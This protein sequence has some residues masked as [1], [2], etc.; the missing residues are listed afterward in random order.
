METLGIKKAIVIAPH[1]DDEILGCG[2]TISKLVSEGSK[3]IVVICTNQHIGAPE[4]C[5]AEQ[6]IKV[7]SEAK[8]VHQ[9]LGVDETI[10][11]DFPAPRLNSFPEY[12]ISVSLSQIFKSHTPDTIFIPFHGDMHQDHKA[13]YRAALV[14]ARP[15]GDQS[16]RNIFSYETL[17]ETDWSPLWENYFRPTLFI[18][19]TGHLDSKLN[20]MSQYKT[21][22]AEFPNPRSL[23]ALTHLAKLRGS[24]IGVGC[25]EAF[26]IERIAI[27]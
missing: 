9:S 12:L 25:A 13:I 26:S 21:Q 19:I 27:K 23:E 20:A 16:I 3:V 10:F 22:I 14:S 2:G 5:S 11:L 6:I 18:D 17:S 1:A 7:R 15:K 4:Q 24:T 8:K